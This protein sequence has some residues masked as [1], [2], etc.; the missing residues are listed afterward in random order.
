MQV[1]NARYLAEHIPGSVYRELPGADGIAWLD[2][3]E[4]LSAAIREFVTGNEPGEAYESVLATVLFTDIVGSTEMVT[5]LGDRRWTELIAGYEALS[6]REL[7]R[8]GGTLVDRAG[9]GLFATFEGAA[10]AIRCASRCETARARSGSRREVASTSASSPGGMDGSAE[11][12]FTSARAS[13][14][15]HARG[16]CSSRERFETWWRGSG[17]RLLDRGEHQ[18]KGI[19]EPLLLFAVAND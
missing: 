6:A 15:R 11:S 14:A 2:G 10:R 17:L 16:R 19:P 13:R 7:E 18:L 4:P 3:W 1:E 8:F 5:R 12:P 9:D